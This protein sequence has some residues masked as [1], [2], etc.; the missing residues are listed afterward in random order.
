MKKI[1]LLIFAAAALMTFPTAASAQNIEESEIKELVTKQISNLTNQF[2]LD[3]IQEFFVDSILWNNIPAMIEEYEAVKKTGATI[4]ESY[5]VVADKWSDATD[6]A[7]EKVFTK[8]QWSKYLKSSF[9][10]EK[11]KRDK[12]IAK[13]K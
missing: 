10:K 2:Q 7:L 1:I 8:E 6:K 13:R 4:Q 12:R 3:E 5:Q 11:E 9:G